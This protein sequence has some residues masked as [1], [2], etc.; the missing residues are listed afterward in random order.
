[1]LRLKVQCLSCL[2]LT[3]LGTRPLR[4]S[5]HAF[6]GWNTLRCGNS[7]VTR[8]LLFPLYLNCSILKLNIKVTYRS[9]ATRVS[10][11]KIWHFWVIRI[12]RNVCRCTFNRYSVITQF[13][14]LSPLESGCV[15]AA[16]IENYNI[17]KSLRV[18]WNNR[19]FW[20]VTLLSQMS[21]IS[22]KSWS[23]SVILLT[24]QP[25]RSSPPCAPSACFQ[26]VLKA[27]V[28]SFSPRRF[29]QCWQH[30]RT[31]CRHFLKSRIS[32]TALILSFLF[33]LRYPHSVPLIA[34]SK[35]RNSALLIE[36]LGI[37]LVL[38]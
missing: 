12:E 6:R 28:H 23:P 20:V 22:R 24:G 13:A 2:T 4:R 25:A 16:L 36:L 30:C 9:F 35:T 3:R 34:C 38:K 31:C 1:M 8:Q 29:V 32:F 11:L 14:K 17:S 21:D 5:L 7:R 37:H 26:P 27:S 19:T 15:I 18:S 10:Q 33:L